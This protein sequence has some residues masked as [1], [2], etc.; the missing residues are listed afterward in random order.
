MTNINENFGAAG[1]YKPVLS[2]TGGPFVVGVDNSLFGTINSTLKT[3]KYLPLT[4]GNF[5][6]SANNSLRNVETVN[7]TRNRLTGGNYLY[8]R[9]KFTLIKSSST[10]L[11][12][13]SK[14]FSGVLD[15]LPRGQKGRLSRRNVP[16]RS[17]SGKNLSVL[18][19][20]DVAIN[21]E[22]IFN[23]Y[24]HYLGSASTG[25]SL[26]LDFSPTR[27]ISDISISRE[28]VTKH[29]SRYY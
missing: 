18:S 26:P 14:T 13:P 5:L 7:S 28:L 1:G 11:L 17:I 10:G 15:T 21:S 19:S 27:T 23:E 2:Y 9:P 24:I 12:R 6:D 16:T 25:S 8:T 20:S 3:Y 4:E 29:Y 22:I